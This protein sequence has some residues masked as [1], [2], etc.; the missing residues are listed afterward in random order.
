MEVNRPAIDPKSPLWQ[1]VGS[2]IHITDKE[3]GEWGCI[4]E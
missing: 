4:R 2:H 1:A 3:V